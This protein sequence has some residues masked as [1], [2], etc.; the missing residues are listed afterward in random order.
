LCQHTSAPYHSKIALN[1]SLCFTQV[2]SANH[3][4][5]T[6]QQGEAMVTGCRA[7]VAEDDDG[8]R[9]RYGDE[10]FPATP[11]GISAR[12]WFG[13]SLKAESE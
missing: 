3:R 7:F 12:E 10:G 13:V 8:G 11:P 4:R 5:S 1:L 6:G 9:Y 2:I